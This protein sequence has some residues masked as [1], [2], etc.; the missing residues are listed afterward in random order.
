MDGLAKALEETNQF[1]LGKIQKQVNTA[2][3]LRNWII[4]HYIV[5]YEQKGQDRAHYGA[6]LYK[7][8]ARKIKE[9]GISSVRERHLYI[10]KEFYLTY[11]S[12]LRTVS[13]KSYLAD[14][15]D[16]DIFKSSLVSRS[17]PRQVQQS[18]NEVLLTRFSFS[19]FIELL[20]A[21]TSVKRWF[22]EVQA[23]KNNWSVRELKRAIDSLLYER[24]G[25]SINK[26]QT[27]AKQLKDSRLQPED[28]FRDPYM[29]EFL[30]LQERPSF[31]ENEMESSI[32]NNLQQFLL[33]M[34]RGF[35]FESRQKRITFNN[36]HFKIDLVFYH[37]ILRC[38]ILIDLKLADFTP[39][40]VG[41]MNMYLNY[42]KENE[43]EK[44]DQPP[45]GIILCAG[46]SELLV[47]YATAGLSQK[48]FV[49]K[50]LVNL[51]TEKQLRE[52]IEREQEKGI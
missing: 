17:S 18:D 46:K 3:T 1:F 44:G 50:Y 31:S 26:E 6:K 51:P 22:Y 49:S 2:L 47:K 14:F 40:D 30:G 52:L 7:E 24:T 10:C 36:T 37:R 42:F 20:R 28:V 15:Q 13:A 43:M 39:A 19:H 9:N 48:V 12:I 5:E 21:E 16:K 38:H 32:I 45:I 11:P 23:L 8:I 27:I 29:L 35:C 4:G 34:G 33:E 41:Q 25:L